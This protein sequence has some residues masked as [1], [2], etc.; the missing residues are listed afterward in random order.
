MS[1]SDLF[2][3]A[4]AVKYALDREVELG[5]PGYH[6]VD[7][8]EKRMPRLRFNSMRGVAEILPPLQPIEAVLINND[9]KILSK[10][11]YV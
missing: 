8:L 1:C 6:F 7:L 9:R 10:W 2:L 5:L 11:V 3:L 4:N